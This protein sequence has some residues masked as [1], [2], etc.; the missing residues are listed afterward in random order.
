MGG[1]GSGRP[2]FKQKAESCLSLNVNLMQRQGCLKAGFTGNWTWSRD[3]K[4]ISQIGFRTEASCLTLDYHISQRAAERELTT[5]S[6][7][8]TY[9]DCNYGGQRPYFRCPGVVNGQHCGRRVSKL[10][11]GGRYFLCR[12]CYSIAYSSQSEDRHDRLLRRANKLRMSLGGSPGT[13]HFIASKPKGMWQRTY[14]RKQF[15][16]EWCEN[17]ANQSFLSKYGHLLSK[18]ELEIYF[19]L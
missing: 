5:Q 19:G 1:Y 8:L 4:V 11:S 12:H 18:D 7:R 14:Q 3:G 9:T 6:V 16:I 10:F 13:A 15:E 17:Q 2:G